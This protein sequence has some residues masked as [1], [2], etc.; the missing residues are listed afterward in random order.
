VFPYIFSI[1]IAFIYTIFNF[2]IALN[3]LKF[4]P[5]S[6]LI[7]VLPAPVIMRWWTTYWSGLT[8]EYLAMRMIQ[9]TGD[10]TLTFHLSVEIGVL[11]LMAAISIV[12]LICTKGFEDKTTVSKTK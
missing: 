11:L 6:A 9:F 10:G 3:M 1:I 4:A 7:T 2:G 8:P 12:M 5:D